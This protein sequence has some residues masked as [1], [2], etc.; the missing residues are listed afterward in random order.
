MKL[1]SEEILYLKALKEENKTGVISNPQFANLTK[2]N[3]KFKVHTIFLTASP[4]L[5][6]ELYH[7]YT[8]MK[9]AFKGYKATQIANAKSLDELPTNTSDA[10]KS[11]DSIAS[12]IN[13]NKKPKEVLDDLRLIQS[14]EYPLFL[15]VKKFLILIDS[16]LCY[17]YF[18]R[19]EGY[20][21]IYIYIYI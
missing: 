2:S 9:A 10:M 18:M 5:S 3:S 15:T 8:G 17:Q 13:K 16:T 14:K 21:F 7:S 19:E 4:C 11:R 12:G 1:F 20:Y 6:N